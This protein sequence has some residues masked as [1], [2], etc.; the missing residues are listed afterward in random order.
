[1]LIAGVS[2]Q[3]GDLSHNVPVCDVL[4]IV[5]DFV[6]LYS[7]AEDWKQWQELRWAEKKYV[8]WL[9]KQPAKRIIVSFGNHD[10]AAF[11]PDT[12][13]LL[14]EALESVSN[15]IVL[16]DDYPSVVIDGVRFSAFPYTPTIQDRNWAF[17][18]SRSK[19][20][21]IQVIAEAMIHDDTDVLLSHGP[22]MGFLDSVRS[23]RVGCA[24]LTKR[25]IE[26]APTLVL[27]GHIHEQRGRREWMWNARGEL[28]RLVNASLCDENYSVRGAKV[29]TYEIDKG[30]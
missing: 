24:M 12:R 21:T 26:V 4:A 29:Q 14:K 11:A 3:H 25:I 23:E 6:P 1:M 27:C 15:V 20:A 22:P 18:L 9:K 10:I 19:A 8:R 30:E 17:S 16:D 5:G 13:A 7:S 28:T 2:D